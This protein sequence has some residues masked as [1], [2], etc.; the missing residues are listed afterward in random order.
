MPN[1]RHG[2]GA[3]TIDNK[4]YVVAGGEK[5]GGRETSDVVSVFFPQRINN[6]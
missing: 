3:L 6:K 5:A 1:P 4:I 2:L